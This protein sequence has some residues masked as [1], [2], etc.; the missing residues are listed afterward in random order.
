MEL[1]LHLVPG[2]ELGGLGEDLAVGIQEVIA[3]APGGDH[4]VGLN[5]V[6]LHADDM[7]AGGKAGDRHGS[8]GGH[9]D[10]VSGKAVKAHLVSDGGAGHGDGAAFLRLKAVGCPLVVKVI[11][12]VVLGI[13]GGGLGT[14][15]IHHGI[16]LDGRAVCAHGDHEHAGK[17][18]PDGGELFA[19]SAALPLHVGHGVIGHQHNS[20]AVFVG[21]HAGYATVV[22]IGTDGQNIAVVSIHINDAVMHIRQSDFFI[23]EVLNSLPVAEHLQVKGLSYLQVFIAL[24]VDGQI[25][26]AQVV[27]VLIE[28]V[29]RGLCILTV[30]DVQILAGNVNGLL[31][32]PLAK[33]PVGHAIRVLHPNKMVM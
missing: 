18:R 26:I 30:P 3:D 4:L 15:A 33:G 19:G 1:D 29:D 5:A 22:G 8:V 28:A 9:G 11:E 6:L 24:L 14:Q 21:G 7:T 27:Q 13:Q 16:G 32:V 10:A 2:L 23:L 17:L 31:G 25:H 12:N 20:G